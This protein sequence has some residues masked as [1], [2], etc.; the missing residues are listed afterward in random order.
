MAAKQRTAD[1]AQLKKIVKQSQ[2]KM[3]ELQGAAKK[4]RRPGSH[5][6]TENEA[7]G[8]VLCGVAA[9]DVGDCTG[10]SEVQGG[11]A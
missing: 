1:K 3:S 11:D 9:A 10:H 5:T 2:V 6:S 7:R 8:T 4:V